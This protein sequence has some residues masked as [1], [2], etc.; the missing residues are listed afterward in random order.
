MKPP[1]L[2]RA[3]LGAAYEGTMRAF[4]KVVT[5]RRW[6]APL[7]AMALGFGLFLG[8]AIGPGVSGSVAGAPGQIVAVQMP[9]SGEDGSAG[10]SF[11]RPP[12]SP[13]ELPA[14]LKNCPTK[15]SSE[16]VSA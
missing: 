7:S 12:N 6:A 5:D 8:V 3:A 14:R 1:R 9:S 13:V 11:K 15:I 2:D 10:I 4:A 16:S